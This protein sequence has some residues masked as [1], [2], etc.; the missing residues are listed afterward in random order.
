MIYLIHSSVA[1]GT[2]GSNAAQHYLGWCEDSDLW[3]RLREH[4]SL[5]RGA[6]IT[7]AFRRAGGTL[8]LVRVWPEGGRALERHLKEKGHFKSR[9][10]ICAGTL[11][12]AQAVSLDMA[13]SLLTQPDARLSLK[14]TT[15][16]RG[17]VSVGTPTH[18]HGVS[19]QG[20]LQLPYIGSAS[21]RDRGG[22]IL[23]G[24]GFG[25][26][27][28]TKP[29]AGGSAGTKPPSSDDGNTTASAEA[30]QKTDRAT[31]TQ[32]LLL[33]VTRLNE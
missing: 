17:R 21:G 3:R 33:G 2:T 20:V 11:P 5:E 1:I 4:N 10:P 13:S 8:Y 22:T 19:L 24:T 18:R 31:A 27:A 9:C 26:A 32:L 25:V 28:P 23:G 6:S 29:P 30:K 14:R 12:V 16:T 7:K 15:R